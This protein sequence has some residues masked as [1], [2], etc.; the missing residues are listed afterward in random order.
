MRLSLLLF[1]S[2]PP[3]R[4]EQLS[5]SGVSQSKKLEELA[6]VSEELKRTK[7][8]LERAERVVFD[9]RRE[10][11]CASCRVLMVLCRCRVASL[12]YLDLSRLYCSLVGLALL[13][14]HREIDG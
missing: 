7:A 8:A 3:P 14:A 11:T 2:P 13:G 1:S 6:R 12:V 4:P 10:G 9:Q 5:D